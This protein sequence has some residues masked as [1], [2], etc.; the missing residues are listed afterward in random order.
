VLTC[1]YL[2]YDQL[3]FRLAAVRDD[4]RGMTTTE[5]VVITALLVTLAIGAVA[6][7][8]N[9]VLNKAHSINL[10]GTAP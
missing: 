9:T 5:M 4:D 10:E 7:I 1:L 6:I 8:S 2:V 3:R